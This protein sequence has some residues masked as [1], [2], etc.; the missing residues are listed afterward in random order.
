MSAIPSQTCWRCK[1]F[2]FQV[3]T[4][5]YSDVTPGADFNLWCNK[6]RWPGL[7]PTES[8]EDFAKAMEIG[9]TCPEYEAK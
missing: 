3:A 6:M 2:S 7:E 4:G 5:D 8:Q 9:F 1:H